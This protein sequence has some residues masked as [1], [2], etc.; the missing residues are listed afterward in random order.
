[1]VNLKWGR[2]K[3]HIR[4]HTKPLGYNFENTRD[5]ISSDINEFR[6]AILCV[7]DAAL[8]MHANNFV[9]RDIRWPNITYDPESDKYLLIDF[10][11]I[12][13]LCKF[14][15]IDH[16]ENDFCTPAIYDA[17]QILKLFHEDFCPGAYR[18]LKSFAAKL[19]N[20]QNIQ[21]ETAQIKML[22]WDFYEKWSNFHFFQLANY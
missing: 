10:E 5:R 11:Q 6:K 13:R 15:C 8:S 18:T 22:F 12:G 3:Y 19:T 17:A 2:L 20:P 21:T 1:M 16:E 7:M 4:I 9:H 14:N